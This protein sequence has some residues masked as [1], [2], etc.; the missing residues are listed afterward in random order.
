MLTQTGKQ[1]VRS[2]DLRRAFLAK[3]LSRKFP[4]NERNFTA[5]IDRFQ[6]D[7]ALPKIGKI[8]GDNR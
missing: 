7:R 4:Q 2:E 8:L 6:S 3:K 5:R 1:G